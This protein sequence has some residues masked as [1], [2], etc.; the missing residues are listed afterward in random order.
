M[1]ARTLKTTQD[2]IAHVPVDHFDIVNGPT[3]ERCLQI[4]EELRNETYGYV[5]QLFTLKTLASNSLFMRKIK[6]ST[7][8]SV[9]DDGSFNFTAI[10]SNGI[11]SGVYEPKTRTG[12]FNLD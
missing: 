3:S 4:M 5:E 8:F 1:P 2:L 6:L 9:L 7:I 10:F 11:V 12:W